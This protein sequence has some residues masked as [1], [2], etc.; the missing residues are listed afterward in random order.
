MDYL[1]RI[2]DCVV[3]GQK[4]PQPPGVNWHGAAWRRAGN[5]SHFGLLLTTPVGTHLPLNCKENQ[6]ILYFV[7]QCSTI[8]CFIKNLLEI[9]SKPYL[10]H[11]SNR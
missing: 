6:R 7:G 4:L 9:F 1:F 11:F 8:P 3:V 2:Y 5:R 10:E